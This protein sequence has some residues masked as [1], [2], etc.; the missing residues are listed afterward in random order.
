[1]AGGSPSAGT[2]VTPSASGFLSPLPAGAFVTDAYGWRIHPIKKTESF[3]T[4]V[5]LAAN[6]GTAIYATAAGVVVAASYSD[7]YGYYV[8]LSHGNGY[9]SF[10][11]HMTNYIV[12]PGDSVSQG[13]IIGY[14]GSTGV[15]ST[16]PHLHF[17]ISVNGSTVNPMEYI[18]LS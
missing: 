4:G 10:Y 18:T 12:A 5:D 17:E 9:G 6:Q 16:G 8:S 1:M 7:A 11:G 15:Y 3:H 14:V 13:Q 2:A